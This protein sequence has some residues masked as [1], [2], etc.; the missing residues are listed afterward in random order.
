MIKLTQ[1][2]VIKQGID[3]YRD[4]GL[5]QLAR[6]GA[7][8]VTKNM[9]TD[10]TVP[11]TMPIYVSV[12]KQI[13]RLAIRKAIEMG[14]ENRLRDLDLQKYKTSDTVFI[15]GSG[16]TI[17][18]ISESKWQHIEGNDSFGLNFW[19]IH[20]HVPTIHVFELPV[21]AEQSGFQKS[22][23][24]LLQYRCEKYSEI[25]IVIKDVPRSVG[26]FDVSRYPEDLISNT[27]LAEEIRF[28]W[29]NTDYRVFNRSIEWFDEN[30]YFESDGRMETGLKKRAS[31]SFLIHMAVR[32]GYDDIVL[33]GVDMNNSK[34]FYNE[35]RQQL[36]KNGVPL[37]PVLNVDENDSH[38]TND[39]TVYRPIFE[40]VL[41]A[42]NEN[43][44]IPKNISLYTEST[45]SA[46]HPELP[47]YEI[48]D[49]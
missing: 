46:T 48:E 40:N 33:C 5:V 37:P 9:V 10:S 8:F 43:L 23:Y 47:L 13:Q 27:Y 17:N 12:R 44:L 28:P 22:Y 25:P 39:P 30:G 20:E 7:L 1:A 14:F 32:M 36:N 35:N 18:D 24:E 15:L 45:E 38:R 31:V 41:Y 21:N 16:S 29:R 11:V 42:L 19:P 49:W 3:T 2:S 4:E 26:H 34:Y 6:E